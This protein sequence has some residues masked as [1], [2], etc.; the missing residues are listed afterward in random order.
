MITIKLDKCIDILLVN[1]H[2]EKQD[3]GKLNWTKAVSS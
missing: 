1:I 2:C 3:W